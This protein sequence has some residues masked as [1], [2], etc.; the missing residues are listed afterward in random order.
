VSSVLTGLNIIFQE[1]AGV[2]K[3]FMA[4]NVQAAGADPSSGLELSL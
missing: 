2:K 4:T 1:W 3:K